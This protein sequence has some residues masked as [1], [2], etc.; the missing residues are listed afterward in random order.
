M[1]GEWAKGKNFTKVMNA[2]PKEKEEENTSARSNLPSGFTENRT[3]NG[4]REC[5][6]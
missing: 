2:P 6:A 3:P 4:K 1:V 5:L